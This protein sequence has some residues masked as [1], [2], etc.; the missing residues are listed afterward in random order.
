MQLALDAATQAGNMGEVPVGAVVVLPD[1]QF[2]TA[3][4]L[5]ISNHDTTA[6]AEILAMRQASAAIENYR[7]SGAKLY[8]T[9]EPCTMCAG[10]IAF[11]RVDELIFAAAD[12]KGGAVANGVRFFDQPTCHHK[13]TVQQIADEKLRDQA[14]QILK[15]F[16]K[17]RRL[18]AKN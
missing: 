18:K 8:V 5:P 14:S 1:G 7:L 3:H 6:H 11:A 12:E 4:N 17:Q 13:I 10:A 2:F 9:L 16:F 15:D